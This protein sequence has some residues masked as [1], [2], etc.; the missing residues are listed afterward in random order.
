MSKSQLDLEG[1]D[2]KDRKTKKTPRGEKSPRNDKVNLK[3]K[4]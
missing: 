3:R 4:R 1:L 2:K